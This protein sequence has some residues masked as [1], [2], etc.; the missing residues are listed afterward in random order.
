MAASVPAVGEEGA[1]KS[2]G[3]EGGTRKAALPQVA[4]LN[5]TAEQ[6][7]RKQSRKVKKE[8]NRANSFGWQVFNE[9]R[10]ACIRVACSRG[11]GHCAL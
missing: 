9:V 8:E 4:L 11:R 1:V 5:E 10:R 6:A 2:E 3:A 7:E